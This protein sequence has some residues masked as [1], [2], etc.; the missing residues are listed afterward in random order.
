[1]L[2]F[3]SP[4]YYMRRTASEDVELDGQPIRKGQKLLMYYP[5]ANRDEDVFERP[6]EFDIERTPNHHLAFGVGEHFCLGTHLARLETRVMF[7]G[8]LERMQDIEIS[9]P[10]TWLRSNLIDGV[11][12]IPMKFTTPG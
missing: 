12:S 1:M 2:R 4:V 9:G 6:D 11:K 8:I 10:V 7:E 5:S 3:R